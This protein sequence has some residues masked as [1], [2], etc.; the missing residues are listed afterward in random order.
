MRT[1][2]DK[3]KLGQLFPGD[4][5]H[6]NDARHGPT[7]S[8]HPVPSRPRHRASSPR[9]I[10]MIFATLLS[11]GACPDSTWRENPSTGKCYKIPRGYVGQW[12][13]P[14]K[15]GAGASM[16][17]PEDERDNEFIATWL[18][19]EGISGTTRMTLWLGKYY[20]ASNGWSKCAGGQAQTLW[21]FHAPKDQRSSHVAEAG[22]TTSPFT[23]AQHT[24]TQ[25]DRSTMSASTKVRALFST[26]PQAGMRAIVCT[27][28]TASTV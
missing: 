22:L 18:R 8:R 25:R 13:C 23:L 9:C 2:G 28:T 1:R 24:P 6:Q 17:C 4:F 14:E 20:T 10:L 15:C 16:A 21:P 11:L 5:V 7:S 19:T 12:S 26:H 3:L 27:G